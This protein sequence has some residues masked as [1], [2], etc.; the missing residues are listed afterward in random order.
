MYFLFFFCDKNGKMSEHEM[1]DSKQ[2][3]LISLLLPLIFT[4]F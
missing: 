1:I 4:I 3:M 2:C